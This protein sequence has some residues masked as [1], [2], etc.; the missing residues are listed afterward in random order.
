MPFCDAIRDVPLKPN[1]GRMAFQAGRIRTPGSGIDAEGVG[2]RRQVNPAQVRCPGILAFHDPGRQRI[3][4]GIGRH[5]ADSDAG[6]GRPDCGFRLRSSMRGGLFAWQAMPS[7]NS[8]PA[9]AESTL[10][11]D[12]FLPSLLACERQLITWLFPS[13]AR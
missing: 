10:D 4:V 6:A 7:T 12:M 2:Y 1:A 8:N 11:G 9:A 13:L 5:D 3:A